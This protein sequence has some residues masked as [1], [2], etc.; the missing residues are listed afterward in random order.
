MNSLRL[1]LYSVFTR[2]VIKPWV[3]RVQN[4]A[5][6][7]QAFENHAKRMHVH[8]ASADYRNGTVSGVPVTWVSRGAIERDE[9]LLYVHGGGFIVGSP[10]THKHMVAEIAGDLGI[11]AVMPRYRLAPEHPFPSGFDD[12]VTTYNGLI[13]RG[14]RADQIILGG[15]SAGG[16][17]V[18]ALLAYLSDTN[19]DLPQSAFV[20]SPVVDMSGGFGS[21]KSNAKSEVLLCAD[22]F[23]ELG[24]MYLGDQDL[25]QPYASPFYAEFDRCPPILFH[26]SDG[27][28]LRDDTLE[29][30]SKLVSQ[31]HVVLVRS[32][33]NAF[34]VF[35]IMTGHFPEARAAIKDIVAFIKARRKPDDS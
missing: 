9:V 14:L 5:E 34:H 11:E 19:A 23:D 35:Q 8:P 29:M 27:E 16:N 7:R 13:D 32:W 15:D 6:A 3:A 20:I 24:A 12:V 21:L 1:C 4:P 18:L 17:L 30:Q 25:K 33:P 26:H 31:G 22:R 2:L 10:D 28:M